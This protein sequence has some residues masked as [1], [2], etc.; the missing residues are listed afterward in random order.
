MPYWFLR[1]ETTTGND[2][3]G[4]RLGLTIIWR[5]PDRRPG[6]SHP[7]HR[8]ISSEKS[9]KQKRYTMHNNQPPTRPEIERMLT[10]LNQAQT[11]YYQAT[12]R[13]EKNDA[14][15]TF[16]SAWDWL[17]QHGIPIQ[18]DAHTRLWTLAPSLTL[19]IG[20]N[21]YAPLLTE[22]QHHHVTLLET[23]DCL[24]AI[25]PLGTRKIPQP[26]IPGTFLLTLP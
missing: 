3:G 22:L 24:K 8:Q 4:H 9:A 1:L 19:I 15:C 21:T 6:S 23:G 26:D 17:E 16:Q 5:I 12:S 18:Q 11:H 25:F 7:V 2:P 13:I 14:D 10:T 20:S